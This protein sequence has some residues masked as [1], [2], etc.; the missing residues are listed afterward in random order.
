MKGVLRRTP[1]DP[2]ALRGNDSRFARSNDGCLW[3]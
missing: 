2:R 3:Q 1:F